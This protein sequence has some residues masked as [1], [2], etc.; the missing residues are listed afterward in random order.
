MLNQII[1]VGRIEKIKKVKESAV[2][3]LAVPQSL[4]NLNGEYDTNF[5]DVNLYKGIA[6]QT[7][8]YCKIGDTIGI[9]GRLQKLE[10]DK[11][12]KLIAEKVTFLTSAR[13]DNE[14]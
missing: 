13:K 6:E 14:E 2:I 1:L 4:K 9:K 7:K 12:I 8:E 3:T 5:I 10:N 11:K